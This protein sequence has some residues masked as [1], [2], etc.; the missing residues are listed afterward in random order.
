M[1]GVLFMN[2]REKEYEE[3][4]HGKEEMVKKRARVG[5]GIYF[6]LAFASISKELIGY[7]YNAIKLIPEP[8]IVIQ[9]M[10][11]FTSISLEG[12]HSL[13]IGNRTLFFLICFISLISF[14]LI[15]IGIYLMIFN[16]FLIRSKLKF[17][18]FLGVGFFFW[19]LVGFKAS[20]VLMI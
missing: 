8:A 14:M 20:L 15:L 2:A 4:L 7:F 6:I 12:I 16:K 10:N 9:Y 1:S 3:K 19:I 13:D 18:S 17:M 5:M 11:S